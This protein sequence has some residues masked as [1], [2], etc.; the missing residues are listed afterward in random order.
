MVVLCVL[1]STRDCMSPPGNSP[2]SSPSPSPSL[3]LA[4]PVVVTPQCYYH[5]EEYSE[6]LRLALAAGPHFNVNERGEYVDTIVSTCI[7]EYTAA[8]VAGKPVDARLEAIVNRMFARCFADGA[9]KQALGAALEARRLDMVHET[10]VRATAAETTANAGAVLA[11]AYELANSA[12]TAREFRREVLR[13]LVKLHNAQPDTVGAGG[14]DYLALCRVLQSLDDAP[15]VAGI[16]DDLLRRGT[17]A[18]P[19]HQV[20]AGENGTAA[21]SAAGAGV[22][23]GH[24]AAASFANSEAVLLAYQIGFD[25]VDSENQQFLVQLYQ[26]LPAAAAASTGDAGAAAAAAAGSASSAPANATSS[27]GDSAAPS[28]PE[29]AYQKA[30]VQLK[31]ILDGSLSCALYLDFMCRHSKADGQILKSVKAAL[32]PTNSV[33]HNATVVAHSYMFCGT[34]VDTFLRN[35]LEWLSRASNWAKFT[36]SA[37]LGVIHKGHLTGSRTILQSYL[38]QPGEV[39][40][41][42]FSE[43]GALYALGLIHANRGASTAAGIHA[44]HPSHAAAGGAGAAAAAATAAATAGAPEEDVVSYLGEQL[45]SQNETLQ[46]GACLGLGLAA[47]ASGTDELFAKLMGVIMNDNAVAGEA[48]GLAIGLVFLGKGP[49][50]VSQTMPGE[51]EDE[52]AAQTLLRYAHQTHHEKIIRGIALGLAFMVYGLE[53]GADALIQQMARDGDPLI[54]YGA[55][56]AVGLA[57]CGTGNNGAL[58]QLLHVAVSD[59]S[60]DVRRAAVTNI[61]FVLCRS[62]AEV[63]VVVSQL[64]E[65]YNAHVRYGATMALGIACAGTGMP[66]AVGVLEPMLDDTTDF[67]RQGALLALGMVL[68]EESEA[69]LP[70]AK[71]IRDRLLALATDKHQTTMTK[72][73]AIM[74]LGIIDAGGRNAVVS[75]M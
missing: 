42:A 54:R 4:I 10:L 50:W 17:G 29:E 23:A 3:A 35:N 39:T 5:L 16:L 24:A 34:T 74:S 55:M 12:V 62:P 68:Q 38:P 52:P 63:P 47:M 30:L 26:A 45:Q 11:H 61:G 75:L 36:A 71:K 67:V 33:L 64:A 65:S 44:R 51:T 15:A 20:H 69:H 41:S 48:A 9:Y 22:S 60:D 49:A 13:E 18:Q 19:A 21:G 2:H 25:T 66:E 70:K 40:G 46:H 57:Y 72:M 31:S 1:V 7:D 56:Y 43:G 6:A 27:G 14:R 37:S 32:P 59:V 53:E 73:G 58:R 8:R 28:T